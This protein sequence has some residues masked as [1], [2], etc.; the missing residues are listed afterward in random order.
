[1]VVWTAALFVIL[2]PLIGQVLEPLVYGHSTG[3]TPVAVIVSATFWTWIWGPV[4]LI[5]STPLAVCLAVLG[6]HI[7]SLRFVEILIGDEPPLTPAQTFYQRALGGNSDEAT[8]ELEEYVEEH[9]SLARCYD[10]IVLEA[11]SLAQVDALRGTL[12]EDNASRINHVIRSVLADMASQDGSL[13]IRDHQG[14]TEQTSPQIRPAPEA[15]GWGGGGQVLCIAGPGHFDGAAC[16]MLAQLLEKSGVPARLE[17]SEAI[18][19]LNI[20]QLNTENVNMVCLSYF[21]LGAS[22]THL[23]Y[24]IRRMRRRILSAKVVACMWGCHENDLMAADRQALGADLS[25][26]TLTEVVDFCLKVPSEGTPALIAIE[27]PD[28]A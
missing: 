5:L 2:E 21:S 17:S 10:D 23:R 24:A 6:R 22:S 15:A 25:A 4:G 26:R 8:D 28:A 9:G 19:S 1:M 12:N 16:Q 27:H 11:L 18:S 7:E 13:E 14:K 3:L 20:G